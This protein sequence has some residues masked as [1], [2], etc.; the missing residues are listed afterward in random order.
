MYYYC[1][2]GSDENTVEDGMKSALD[3]LIHTVVDVHSL[4]D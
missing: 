2:G 4:V 3:L 1:K